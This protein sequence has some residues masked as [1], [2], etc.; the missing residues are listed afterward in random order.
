MRPG[1]V[2]RSFRIVMFL[3][4]A[5]GV[6]TSIAARVD[7]T[8]STGAISSRSLPVTMRA[9]S[10]MSSMSRA[11]AAALRS[12]TCSARSS[13]S[14]FDRMREQDVGPAEHRIER[15]P[16][17]VRQ[18]G[19]EFVLHAQRVFRDR[20]RLLGDGDL[21]AQLGFAVHT[22]AD[23][24]DDRHGADDVVLDEERRDARALR[25]VAGRTSESA[26]D[27]RGSGARARPLRPEARPCSSDRVRDPRC[28]GNTSKSVPADDRRG[29]PAGDALQP[30]IPAGESP[31]TCRW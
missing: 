12:M 16:Q 25:H 5:V 18:R 22:L 8:R 27:D 19:E 21:P 4:C 1:V 24:L 26:R 10:S 13:I 17:L 9:M 11:C 30:L 23:V 31:E 20:A 7:D 15:R 6:T 3:A 2:P 14:G 28:S 29:G